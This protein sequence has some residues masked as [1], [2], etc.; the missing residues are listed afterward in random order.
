M[1]PDPHRYQRASHHSEE[2]RKSWKKK[3]DVTNKEIIIKESH[4]ARETGRFE[5]LFTLEKPE[6]LTLNSNTSHQCQCQCHSL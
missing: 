3:K 5:I 6:D 1:G 4:R 2:F